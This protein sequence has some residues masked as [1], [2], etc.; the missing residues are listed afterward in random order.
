M[1]WWDSNW[2]FRE[3]LSSVPSGSAYTSGVHFLHFDIDLQS[4]AVMDMVRSDYKD[5]RIIYTSGVVVHNVPCYIASGVSPAKIYFPAQNKIQ[6]NTN[7]GNHGSGWDYYLYYGNNQGHVEKCSD[8]YWNINFPQA[9]Y[10]ATTE[11]YKLVSTASGYRDKCL[12]RLNDDPSVGDWHGFKDATGFT[13]GLANTGVVNC[14][15]KGHDGRLD[16]CSFFINNADAWMKALDQTGTNITFPSGSFCLD[17]WIKPTDVGADWHAFFTR[18]KQSNDYIFWAD[19]YY[20]QLY[21]TYY[22]G[23]GT[24]SANVIG[25]LTA[26][27][28]THVRI[29]Y[30][31]NMGDDSKLTTY[32]DGTRLSTSAAVQTSL[33]HMSDTGEGSTYVGNE[34]SSYPFD[35]YIE[36]LRFSTYP[37]FASGDYK[38]NVPPDWI[39]NEYTISRG[40][41]EANG[42]PQSGFIGGILRGGVPGEVSGIMGGFLYGSHLQ[43]QAEVGALLYS[44]FAFQQSGVIGGFVYSEAPTQYTECGGY[45]LVYAP[46]D[47]VAI[48]GFMNALPLQN[49]PSG[50]VGG[51]TWSAADQQQAE[52]GGWT[53]G[54]WSIDGNSSTDGLLRVLVKGKD[55]LAHR[56]KFGADAQFTIY[57]PHTDNFDSKIT[58]AKDETNDFD[59]Q[60]EV[61]KTRKNTYIK[62]IDVDIQGSYPWTV[63]VTASGKA[64]DVDNTVIPSGIHN[65]VFVWT[66]GDVNKLDNITASGS[67]FSYTHIYTQSGIYQ[68]IVMGYDKTNNIGSDSTILNFA[69]GIAHPYISLSGSPRS[70]IVPPILT[71]DFRYQ[72]SGVL[73]ATTVFWDYGNGITQYNNSKTSTTQYA[74]AGDYIPYIRIEDNRGIPVVDTLKLNYNR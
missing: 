19:K 3:K 14:V 63:T 59:A 66:D 25:A 7:I 5:V 38:Y 32:I 55:T 11:W 74:M 16:T 12:Y 20:N 37:E 24:V 36:Q 9:P 4:L 21:T 15:T 41:T 31:T 8:T 69:S 2:T 26:I 33:A 68:P 40:L 48:G 22:P 72:S 50:F 43:Q 73:G 67:V 29:A 1:S 6:S 61:Q 56:Q 64:Y 46:Y 44:T 53:I 23:V 34:S 42:I 57:A 58:I 70:A 18:Y 65:A 45:M 52:V 71:V 62:I 49:A 60:L 27:E 30:R 51:L 17:V 39:N 13:S 10:S 47:F 54:T 28:W 35:G